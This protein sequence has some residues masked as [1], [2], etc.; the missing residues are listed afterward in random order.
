MSHDGLTIEKELLSEKDVALLRLR[1]NLGSQT[2]EA[3]DRAFGELLSQGR[4][5]IIVDIENVETL[6]RVSAYTFAAAVRKAGHG[7]GRLVLLRPRASVEDALRASALEC[8]RV[9]K[10]LDEALSTLGPAPAPSAPPPPSAGPPSPTEWEVFTSHAPEAASSPPAGQASTPSSPAP[11]PT[12][13]PAPALPVGPVSG[14][15]TVSRDEF[16]IEKELLPDRNVVVLRLSGYLDA[17]TFERLEEAIA[18]LFAQGRYRII[19]DLAA[20]E[21]ISS[22]GMGVFIGALSEAQE[23]NGNIVLMSP[24]ANVREVMDL[25]GPT[26]IFQVVDDL[27]TALAVF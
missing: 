27:R 10:T 11:S 12:P 4:C 18:E 26:Q 24:T 6:T 21:Y 3:L 16:K 8:L 2:S 19:T 25:L 23:H 9:A 15:T 5:R 1:G 13:Q 22:A 17:H 7:G 20:V 14:R